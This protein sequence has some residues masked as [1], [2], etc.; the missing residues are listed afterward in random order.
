[1]TKRKLLLL[2]PNQLGAMA[3]EWAHHIANNDLIQHRPQ[4]GSMRYGENIYW[5]TYLRGE[6]KISRTY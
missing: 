2:F 5:D 4:T 3:K 6:L 1:M